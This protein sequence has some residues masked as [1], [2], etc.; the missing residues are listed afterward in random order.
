MAEGAK[1]LMDTVLR[2]WATLAGI[3]LA[4]VEPVSRSGRTGIVFPTFLSPIVT[5]AVTTWLFSTSG[6]V[7]EK[8]LVPN[9]TDSV[10]TDPSGSS[11][12]AALSSPR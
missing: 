1:G 5:S 2:R 3:P 8:L 12:R 10:R 11:R 6:I 7:K 9:W 4:V